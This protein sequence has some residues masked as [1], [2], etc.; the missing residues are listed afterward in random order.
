M[1]KFALMSVSLLMALM[2]LTSC[3]SDDDDPKEVGPVA[4]L[5]SETVYTAENGL[6]LTY[7]GAPMLGKTVKFTPDANNG[8]KGTLT[9]SSTFD[10]SAMP[11]DDGDQAPVTGSIA[12]PGVIPG[13]AETV[14]DIILE[15]NSDNATF[16]GTSE[17][18]YCRFNYNGEISKEG[19]KLN[20]TDVKLNNTSLCANWKLAKFAMDD[21]T[22]EISAN[23]I[24]IV[25]ES[26]A[27]INLFGSPTPVSDLLKLLMVM[28]LVNDMTLTLPNALNSVLSDVSFLEDGNIQ[29]TYLD[30][31]NGA[32]EFAKSPLNLMQYVLN[33]SNSMLLFI[34]PQA[35][36]AADAENN[37]DEPENPDSPA[38]AMSRD[39]E[40]TEPAFDIDALLP[41]IMAQL[42][43]ML[44][45]G[46]PMAYNIDGEKLCLY[47]DT[48]ILLPLLKQNVLPLLKNEEFVK[49]II[50]MVAADPDMGYIAMFL[51]DM[52]T[53]IADV[54]EQTTRLE[55]GL[56]FDGKTAL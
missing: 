32:T 55:V 33:S 22:Y 14:L 6:E 5:F 11:L 30:A 19:L 15:G 9:L 16:S 37:P 7:S 54:I 2:P 38:K 3:S 53:S 27:D 8:T 39:G 13:S 56:N 25:W 36:I 48:N 47:L 50:D 4:P 43:P 42:V 10:L 35:V 26:G 29:A 52:L 46:V 40:T 12:G 23:P 44:S 1:K 28:P 18:Q 51:P 49:S 20:I 31:E 45:N 34:N 17:N 21:E 41:N 24:H